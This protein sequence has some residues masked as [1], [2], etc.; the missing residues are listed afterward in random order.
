VA[1]VDALIAACAKRHLATHLF[2]VDGNQ[3]AIARAIGLVALHPSDLLEAQ[4][5]LG[6]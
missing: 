3:A 5:T 6:L 2:T 1:K 4:H